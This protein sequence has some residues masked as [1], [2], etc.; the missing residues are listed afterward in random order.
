MNT[1]RLALIGFGN[2]GQGF[3]QVIQERGTMLEQ[4]F[5]I[6][7][8]VVAVSDVLKGS[9]Y[10]PAG[11]DPGI[12]LDA[13][14]FTGTLNTVSAP[15]HDWNALRTIEESNANV[16]IELSPTDLA[17][18]EPARTHLRRA[19][20]LSKHVITTNKGPIA[21]HYT[22]LKALA[23]AHGVDIGV[24]GTVMS[25]TP[26]I[27]FGQ[28]L[29][30]AAGIRRIQGIVNGT[31]NYILTRMAS[32]ATYAA[33]L[34]EAQ[35]HGYAETTP[36]GDVEGHDAAAKMVI[37]ANLLMDTPLSLLEVKRT[38]ITLLT[39][40]DIRRAQSE[41][42]VWKLIG[43]VEHRNGRVTASVH[44]T[45]L[46]GSH[47]L[48]SVSGALNALTFTTDLLGDVTISGPGA[49]RLETGYALLCDLLAIYQK[50]N[51]GRKR[52]DCSPILR[53]GGQR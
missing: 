37:L 19:L 25:G 18:A 3:A 17:S 52:P 34:E 11:L 6:G 29:L 28:E 24:E 44:P 22:E 2:V 39:P 7:L 45:C 51:Q 40:E 32:G 26:A 16:I 47:P 41:G 46:P 50:Q 21:L 49:G 13:I 9:V 33:A 23:D 35:E 30:A 20:E 48:A 14:R 5:G 8:Q 10:D 31:A 1:Y 36:I 42:N 4:R 38:G 43:R 53:A 12:L 27:H 15:A